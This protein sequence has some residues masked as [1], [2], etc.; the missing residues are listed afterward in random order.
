MT[1]ASGSSTGEPVPVAG[2]QVETAL[3][4]LDHRTEDRWCH[5]CEATTHHRV[6]DVHDKTTGR[7]IGQIVRCEACPP[8][9]GPG[10]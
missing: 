2:R 3:T 6:T 9:K 1:S 5:A 4:V 10:W 7:F 8:P